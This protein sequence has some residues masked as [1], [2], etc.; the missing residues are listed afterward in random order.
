MSWRRA[1]RAVLVG[2]ITFLFALIY[3]PQCGVR[4]YAEN[5]DLIG[6]GLA[7]VTTFL[8]YRFR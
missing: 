2:A 3:V 5:A 1:I 4:I 7:A 6:F 8:A